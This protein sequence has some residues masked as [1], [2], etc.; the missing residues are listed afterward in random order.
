MGV[1][2][3]S[4]RDVAIHLSMEATQSSNVLVSHGLLTQTAVSVYTQ[5]QSHKAPQPPLA[6]IHGPHPGIKNSTSRCVKGLHGLSPQ[7]VDG[8][9][10]T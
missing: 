6:C 1:T 10:H 3:D 9:F 7:G 4:G 5:S 8:V 2:F